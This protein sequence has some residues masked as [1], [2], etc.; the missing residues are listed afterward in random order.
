MDCS[1]L[2]FIEALSCLENKTIFGVLLSH[3]FIAKRANTWMFWRCTVTRSMESSKQ[4]FAVM[5]SPLTIRHLL[6]LVL[7][8]KTQAPLSHIWQWHFFCLSLHNSSGITSCDTTTCIHNLHCA[9]MTRSL[10]TNALVA[11]RLISPCVSN[12]VWRRDVKR[13][14]ELHQRC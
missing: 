5:C 13:L 10:K 9:M 4:Y 12:L 14:N 8:R 11:F 2:V 3:V 7:S 6:P 1:V